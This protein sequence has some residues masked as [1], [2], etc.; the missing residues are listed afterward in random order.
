MQNFS[1]RFFYFNDLRIPAIVKW[2]ILSSFLYLPYILILYFYKFFKIQNLWDWH[3]AFHVINYFDYGFIKRGF[4]GTIFTNLLSISGIELRPLTLIYYL[5][6]II[7]F[8]FLYWKFAILSNVPIVVRLAL[9]LSPATF[10]HLGYDSPRSTDLI[11][12]IIFVGWCLFIRKVN[13]STRSSGLIT[14]LLISLA[15]LN[16]EGSLF[17]ICPFMIS[18]VISKIPRFNNKE[19]IRIIL[20]TLTPI[21]FTCIS[22][23]L[24]GL[25]EEGTFELRSKLS[26]LSPGVV[27]TVSAVIS[28]GTLLEVNQKYMSNTNW[29]SDNPFVITYVLIWLF[30]VY[31]EIFFNYQKYDFV[32]IF[33]LGLSFTGILICSVALDFPRYVAMTLIVNSMALFL[34]MKDKKWSY[35]NKLWNILCFFGILG[36]LSY[37]AINPFPLWNILPEIILQT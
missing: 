1:E 11:W 9:L 2:T 33:L 25:Y 5:G 16:Y 10:Q 31:K 37:S 17:F 23:S 4:S 12:L 8:S 15:A 19:R 24:Y 32:P 35:S 3:L 28:Q 21:I 34:L 18:Y 26:E 30:A 27:D 14:G 20:I 6:L 7:I 36:P 22:L 13:I 29:F